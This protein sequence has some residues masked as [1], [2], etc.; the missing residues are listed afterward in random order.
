MSCVPAAPAAYE[1]CWETSIEGR[2]TAPPPKRCVRAMPPTP[3][4]S[5]YLN[6]TGASG[7]SVTR[8]IMKTWKK[9]SKPWS[10]KAL[11]ISPP[12]TAPKPTR[13]VKYPLKRAILSTVCPSPCVRTLSSAV[14]TAAQATW[15]AMSTARTR[16]AAKRPK[17]DVT[18][19]ALR[20]RQEVQ[21]MLRQDPTVNA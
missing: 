8:P 20:Q 3:S 16:T 17:S 7:A 18:S 13:P 19:L 11:E 10:G 4:A 5:D 2:E 15:T 12:R 9:W 14:K 6:E 21:E 1:E